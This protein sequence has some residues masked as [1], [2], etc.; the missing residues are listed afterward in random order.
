VTDEMM[1][2][3]V[4][5][6]MNPDADFLREMIGFA[7]ERLSSASVQAVRG[8]ADHDLLFGRQPCGPCGPHRRYRTRAR[9]IST[10]RTRRA[11]QRIAR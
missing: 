3:R 6:K 8:C 4:L 1:N 9:P 10:Y 11:F 5:V 7:A 2:L